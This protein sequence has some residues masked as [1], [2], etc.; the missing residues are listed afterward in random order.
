MKTVLLIDEDPAFRAT[1][2]EWLARERW[3][4][5]EAA[6]GDLGLGF[7]QLH[8]PAIV[9]CDLLMPR[10]NGFRLCRIIRKLPAAE[11][12]KIIISSGRG[13]PGDRLTALEAGADEYLVK[14]V[15]EGQLL[16][17]LEK[18]TAPGYQRAPVQSRIPVTAVAG[19][20]VIHTGG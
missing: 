5:I 9:I 15:V 7:I 18:L 6:N 13:Y 3:Q 1:L 16:K 2:A 4:V 8:Q 17:L 19:T 20:N 11:Q 10:C 12:P 14:P